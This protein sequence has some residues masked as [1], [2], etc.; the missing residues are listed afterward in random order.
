MTLST[1]TNY[2]EKLVLWLANTCTRIEIAGSVRRGF[3]VCNDI[4]LVVIPVLFQEKDMLGHLVSERNLAHGFLA[5]YISE[6]TGKWAAK[7]GFIQGEKLTSESKQIMVQLPKCQLDIFLASKENFASR[8]LCR[9]GSREHNIWLCERADK[10]GYHWNPSEG[11]IRVK[12]EGDGCGH[13]AIPR[14]I[15]TDSEEAIY[16]HLQ[17]P[18]IE[19]KDRELAYL[20][21]N[22][23]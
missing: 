5:Q 17:L 3:P 19:P 8:F 14:L 16:K 18:F 15:P 23:K 13:L 7:V 1:A 12:P 6:Q 4:D 21:R 20:Q 2:A 10:F 9:T 11:L 22:F